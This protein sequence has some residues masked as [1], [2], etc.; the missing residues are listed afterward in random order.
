MPY[1]DRGNTDFKRAT[2]RI[3]HTRS[4]DLKS[5]DRALK[6]AQLTPTDAKLTD[7]LKA[8]Q[9]WHDKNRKEFMKRGR[10]TGAYAGLWAEIEAKLGRR[11]AVWSTTQSKSWNKTPFIWVSE[12]KELLD[13][14][15]TYGSMDMTTGSSSLTPC[16]QKK[17]V[18][19]DRNKAKGTFTCST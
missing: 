6:A 5:V 14:M 16:C 15:K 4:G 12:K 11:A 10:A 17:I 2:A 9:H 3:G 19:R 18:F 7:L 1:L 8:L 13:R